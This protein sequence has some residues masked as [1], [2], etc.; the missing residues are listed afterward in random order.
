MAKEDQITDVVLSTSNYNKDWVVEVIVPVHFDF[1]CP[2]L[3]TF[4]PF[5]PCVSLSLSFS[6]FLLL[7][8]LSS[9]AVT[10]PL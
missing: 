4:P 6:V 1:K 7:V 9:S 3:F 5:F 2:P 10:F 8:T